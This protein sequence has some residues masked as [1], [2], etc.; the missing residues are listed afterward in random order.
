MADEVDMTTERQA[1]EAQLIARQ[2]RKPAMP[3]PTGLCLYCME[4]TAEIELSE[5]VPPDTPHFCS[6]ECR[7]DWD[8]EHIIKKRQGLA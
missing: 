6:V 4:P 7:Q 5:A 3:A 8:H 2:T 1:I